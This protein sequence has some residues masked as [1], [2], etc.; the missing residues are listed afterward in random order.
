LRQGLQK[1]IFIIKNKKPKFFLKQVFADWEK[2]VKSGGKPTDNP[3]VKPE[4]RQAA[5]P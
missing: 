1:S 5:E 4:C 2:A 3:S